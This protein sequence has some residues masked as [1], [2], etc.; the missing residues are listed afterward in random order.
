MTW[1]K[2]RS[3]ASRSFLRFALVECEGCSLK[4]F[5]AGFRPSTR[6]PFG[7]P[8]IC[9]LVDLHRPSAL[10]PGFAAGLPLSGASRTITD[11]DVSG[12]AAHCEKYEKKHLR[13]A[14]TRRAGTGTCPYGERRWEVMRRGA[15]GTPRRACAGRRRAGRGNTE[16]ES[17]CHRPGDPACARSSR[18]TCGRRRQQSAM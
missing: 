12:N 11:Y 5:S 7:G 1:R 17:G 13:Q 18:G 15:G 9:A 10:R 8:A 2:A 14:G 3:F 6:T 16:R 4:D